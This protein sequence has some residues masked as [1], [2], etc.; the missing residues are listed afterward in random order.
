MIKI[1]NKFIIFVLVIAVVVGSFYFFSDKQREVVMGSE[2]F[3]LDIADTEALREKGLSYREALSP[4][5]GMLFIFDTSDTHKFWM[6]GM[7]FPIDIIWLDQDKKV[8]YIE[9]SLSPVTYPKAFGPSTPTQYV[10]EI[11]AGD[12]GRLGLILGDIIN[13]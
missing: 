11:P 6:K 10:I 13:F 12:A 9:H 2:V 1:P 3:L 4:N 8:V 5:T 7:N